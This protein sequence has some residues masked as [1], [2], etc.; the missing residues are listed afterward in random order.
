MESQ[1]YEQR[2]PN[3]FESKVPDQA[4]QSKS[5]LHQFGNNPQNGG[6]PMKSQY[7]LSSSKLKYIGDYKSLKSHEFFKNTRVQSC[8]YI[9][10]KANIF[11]AVPYYVP[12]HQSNADKMKKSEYQKSFSQ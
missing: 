6:H 1:P 2:Q 4:I 3:E 7:S 8:S 11:Q 12:P 9:T 5:G 10:R